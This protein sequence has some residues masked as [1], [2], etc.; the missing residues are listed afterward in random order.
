MKKSGK[1]EVKTTLFDELKRY[2][3]AKK[4]KYRH[5]ASHTFAVCPLLGCIETL[6]TFQLPMP[7]KGLILSVRGV[8]IG[9]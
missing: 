7:T 1:N 5:T 2:Q 9:Y 8:L 6:F 4:W 3:S